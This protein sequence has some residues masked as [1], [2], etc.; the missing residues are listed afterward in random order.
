[1]S[2]S[3]LA[4]SL[5]ILH[6]LMNP[7]RTRFFFG[8]STEANYLAWSKKQRLPP[9]AVSINNGATKAFWIGD[10]NAEVVIVYFHGKCIPASFS[11][12]Y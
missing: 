9:E 7:L 6:I 1:M 2:S 12:C 8:G 4:T 11:S 3:A 10:S 5:W